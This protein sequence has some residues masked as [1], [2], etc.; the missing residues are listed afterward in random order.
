MYG[1]V[2]QPVDGSEVKE[3]RNIDEE[4]LHKQNG[5]TLELKNSIFIPKDTV[6]SVEESSEEKTA[7]VVK[8]SKFEP[9]KLNY[10]QIG[11]Q[12]E[13]SNSPSYILVPSN[14]QTSSKTKPCGHPKPDP[15]VD[16]TSPPSDCGC[17]KNLV[18]DIN[19]TN[20]YRLRQSSRS[21]SSSSNSRQRFLNFNI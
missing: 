3:Y 17:A 6:E 12:P 21:S 5:P 9:N 7:P 16:P 4:D 1:H 13:N 20:G 15:T 18:V 2:K 8:P 11:Y 14:S 19:D 10:Y